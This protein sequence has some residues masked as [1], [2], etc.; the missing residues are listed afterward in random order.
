[1]L[2][3]PE[4]RAVSELL[5]GLLQQL[6][7]RGTLAGDAAGVAPRCNQSAGKQT[8]SNCDTPESDGAQP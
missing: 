1:M 5:P 2:D 3:S 4:R 8:D 7:G 6:G